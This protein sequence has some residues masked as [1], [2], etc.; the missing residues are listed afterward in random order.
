MH[1]KFRESSSLI[2]IVQIFVHLCIQLT[3]HIFIAYCI[4]L[5]IITVFLQGSP[6]SARGKSSSWKATELSRDSFLKVKVFV[7]GHEC[8]RLIMVH[9]L[10]LD[11]L[12]KYTNNVLSCV[13][14]W[15]CYKRFFKKKKKK[16]SE[17]LISHRANIRVR[18]PEKACFCFKWSGWP[19]HGRRSWGHVTNCVA[20]Q[21]MNVD[22]CVNLTRQELTECTFDTLKY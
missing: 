8:A 19:L 6:R 2:V 5:S 10:H 1:L 15:F 20:L 18:F 16:F 11:L 9:H 17:L 7:Y 14:R 22:V 12:L 4:S 3:G 13:W 21:S